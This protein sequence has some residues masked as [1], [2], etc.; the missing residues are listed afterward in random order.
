MQLTQRKKD[1]SLVLCLFFGWSLFSLSQCL[2]GFPLTFQKSGGVETLNCPKTVLLSVNTYIS[3]NHGK[4]RT[5]DFLSLSGC[6][7]CTV[8]IIRSRPRLSI[9]NVFLSVH[10]ITRYRISLK[11]F[12]VAP[13][14]HRN[15]LQHYSRVLKI[16][17]CEAAHS[18]KHSV[19]ERNNAL[20]NKKKKNAHYH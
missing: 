5:A 15:T 3:W 16:D 19:R 13:P 17:P 6:V 14:Q 7:L 8:T 11:L 18:G 20:K 2:R 4:Y 9:Y 12:T 10:S 1:P